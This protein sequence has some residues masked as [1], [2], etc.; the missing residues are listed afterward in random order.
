M[1]REMSVG[2][3]SRRSRSRIS[4]TGAASARCDAT[5]STAMRSTSRPLDNEE[6]AAVSAPREQKPAPAV[7]APVA[8]LRDLQSSVAKGAPFAT[9]SERSMPGDWRYGEARL[10]NGEFTPGRTQLCTPKV[11]GRLAGHACYGEMKSLDSSRCSTQ[12]SRA[13]TV[14]GHRS[15]H[16]PYALGGALLATDSDPV[17]PFTLTTS[18]DKNLHRPPLMTLKLKEPQPIDQFARNHLSGCPYATHEGLATGR[19]PSESGSGKGSRR[20]PRKQMRPSS[21]R[22]SSASQCPVLNGKDL[23]WGPS[24]GAAGCVKGGA[25]T[26]GE[27]D[28]SGLVAGSSP[29]PSVSNA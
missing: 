22:S 23:L 18:C 8:P 27:L 1:A 7:K 24:Q 21:R 9:Y 11:L 17:L 15:G 10:L 2:S 20:E 25:P 12:R 28:L 29:M 5:A 13:T 4:R 6:H 16:P 26:V 14:G 3:L 19:P